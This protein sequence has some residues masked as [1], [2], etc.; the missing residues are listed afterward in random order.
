VP[1]IPSTS[2]ITHNRWSSDLNMEHF[3]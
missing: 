1:V 2:R 3:A